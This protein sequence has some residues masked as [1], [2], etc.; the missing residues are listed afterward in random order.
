MSKSTVRREQSL[1]KR[2]AQ[3]ARTNPSQFKQEWKKLLDAW[4]AE[5]FL[6][7]NRLRDE[8]ATESGQLPVYGV[9]EKAQRLLALCGDEAERLVGTA[10]RAL[11]EHDCGKAFSQAVAPHMYRLTNVDSNYRLMKAGTHRPP[12]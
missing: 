6:R 12:R 11:L 5:A 9:L 2:L 10:T 4:S 3:L 8:V 7:G 1:S